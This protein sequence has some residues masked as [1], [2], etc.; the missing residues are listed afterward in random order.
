MKARIVCTLWQ[1]HH[2]QHHANDLLAQDRRHHTANMA[3]LGLIRL[4]EGWGKGESPLQLGTECCTML[5]ESMEGRGPRWG[6]GGGTRESM[7]G[8]GRVD[9][10]GGLGGGGEQG[11]QATRAA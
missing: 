4:G 1:G 3:V 2:C 8:W 11:A 6:V 9:G 5:T 10:G 7:V